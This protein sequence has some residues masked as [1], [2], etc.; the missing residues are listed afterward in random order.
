MLMI[1]TTDPILLERFQVCQVHLTQALFLALTFLSPD[2]AACPSNNDPTP[3]RALSRAITT[4]NCFPA[5]NSSPTDT[6]TGRGDYDLSHNVLALSV[7]KSQEGLYLAAIG[8]GLI[9]GVSNGSAVE[10]Q[11]GKEFAGTERKGYPR[12]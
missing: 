11:N 6:C 5:A 7:S 12:D 9:K 2:R 10:A 3:S 4:A 1:T 8:P